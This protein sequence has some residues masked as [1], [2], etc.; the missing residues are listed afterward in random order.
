MPQLAPDWSEKIDEEGT[1][2]DPLYTNRSRNRMT[3]LF[4]HGTITSIPLRLR[5]VS[6]FCWAIERLGESDAEDEERY[7][8]IKNIE[9]LFCLSS[10]YQELRNDQPTALTAM[11]GNSEFNYD[12]EAFDE[13]RL[14]DL[15]LLKNDSYAYQRFY[16]NLL[17]KFLLKR[18]EFVLTEAGSE[19]ASLVGDRLG[20]RGDRILSCAEAGQ[21]TRADF[22]TFS[23]DFANQSLYYDDAFEDE[24]VALQKVLLGFL[25]WEGDKQDG[26]A[27]LQ[28]AIP[29]QISTDVRDH[30]H[31]TL[32]TGDIEDVN[33]NK[34]YQK[35]HRG[36]HHYRRAFSLFLL[37]SWQLQTETDDD[38]ISLTD[39]DARFDQFRSLM[40]IYWQQVYLGYALE[41]KLEATTTFLNSRIPARH[42]YDALVEAAGDADRVQAEV[43]GILEGI[44]VAEG[45]ED[46]SPAQ[47]TRNLLL[48]GETPRTKLSVS[49]ASSPPDAPLDLGTVQETVT[50]WTSDGWETVPARPGVKRP[51][52]VLLSRAVRSSLDE[53]RANVDDEAAQFRHWS[54]A[55]ARSTVLILLELAR[56]RHQREEREWLYNYAYSR[57]D[58]Q[59]A[60]LPALDRYVSGLD[61]ATPVDE[62]ARRLLREQVVATHL[63]VFYDRLSPGNLK[64]ILSFDQDDRLCLEAQEERGE[65]PSRARASF[66]RFDEMNILLRDCGLLLDDPDG[67]FVVSEAG[68]DLLRRTGRGEGS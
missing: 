18:G 21:A 47:L 41:A 31:E 60:S 14:E 9:K 33:A 5:Y 68:A 27:H 17:Q 53:L 10:R 59:F 29:E 43:N 6:I 45:S 44:E 32:E 3:N 58:S 54:Q 48:Y 28:E 1:P 25:E 42:P 56:F 16:E 22:E 39:A 38:P 63:R 15:E 24:R 52:E 4:A 55:L 13:I 19:L 30:L 23:Y 2:V 36:Y 35:F 51:N 49:I 50:E 65:R 57:L 40:Y 67:E 46:A 11:D 37:R 34:L 66:V 20:E 8:R 12:D 62:V 64:R 26:T 7:R 61:P